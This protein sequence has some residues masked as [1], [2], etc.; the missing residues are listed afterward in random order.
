MRHRLKL[1]VYQDDDALL[2]ACLAGNEDAWSLLVERYCRLVYSIARKSGL[3]EDDAADAVQ[4][5]FTNVLRHL[6]SLRDAE[7]FSSWLI[8]TAHRECWRIARAKTHVSLDGLKEPVDPDPSNDELVIEWEHA[9]LM[10]QALRRLDDRCR[11]L[12]ESL[13]LHEERPSY[14][15]ISSGLGIAVGSIGPIRARCLQRLRSHLA[16]LGV[17]DARR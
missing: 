8:T 11:H 6:E 2:A 1:T 12:L 9:S 3:D 5:V 15:A 14:D 17:D 4:D 13:F 7:R 16:D 10:Q